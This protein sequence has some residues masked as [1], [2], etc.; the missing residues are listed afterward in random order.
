M[1]TRVV[2]D[3]ALV[4]HN[5]HTLAGHTSHGTRQMAVVKA[6]GYGHGAIPVARAALDAGATWLGVATVGEGARLRDAGITAPILV[7]GPVAPGDADSAVARDLA[8]TVFA[9][10]DLPEALD[11]RAATHGRPAR[12]HLKVDTGMGRVGV[13]PAEAPDLADRLRTLPNLDLE[14]VFTHFATADEQDLSFARIQLDRFRGVLAALE[15]RGVRPTL[16]HAANTAATLALPDSHLDLVRN[17]I[18][19]YGLWPSAVL[20]GAA[21]LRPALRW[22]ARVAQVKTVPPGTPLSYGATHVTRGRRRIATLPVGYGDGYP[23]LL[24]NR[25]EVVAAGR[26]VPI[27]G[28]VCM[29]MTLVD[30]STVPELRA[31]DEAVLIGNQGGAGITAD[32][33]AAWTGTINYEVTCAIGGRVPRDYR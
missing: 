18:G 33:I 9:Q 12:V 19:I 29:D 1:R 31:G 26:R 30:V 15:A 7:L 10:G 8:V 14:G 21:D 5:V 24:S 20:R 3:L 13:H 25:G 17:G 2:I 28:R 27:V 11:R 32:A 22:E 6:D 16:R 23:R 4:R